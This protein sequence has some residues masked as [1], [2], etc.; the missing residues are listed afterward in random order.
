VQIEATG[1]ALG[2]VHA[3]IKAAIG[4]IERELF[5]LVERRFGALQGRLDAF[6]PDRPRPQPKDFRFAGERERDDGSVD[7]PNPLTPRRRVLDS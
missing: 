6:M 1:Q 3:E 7:L 2:E 5:T 4:K